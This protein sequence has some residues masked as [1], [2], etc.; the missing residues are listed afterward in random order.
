MSTS[1]S[2]VRT[3]GDHAV[4]AVVEQPVHGVGVVHRPHDHPD[5]G[6]VRA[7]H[8]VVAEHRHPAQP[9]R[10]VRERGGA[11]ATCGRRGRGELGQG[12]P[13]QRGLHRPGRRAPAAARSHDPRAPATHTRAAAPVVRQ[14]LGQRRDDGRVLDVDRSARRPGRRRRASASGSD[15][16]AAQHRQRDQLGERARPHRP[17]GAGHP[18]EPGVVERDELPVGGQP[19]VGL[20][21]AHAER[22]GAARTPR[23][24]SRRR[25]PRRRGGRSASGPGLSQY[26]TRPGCGTDDVR[27]R[28]PDAERVRRKRSRAR[29]RPRR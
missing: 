4:H 21:V 13:R 11:V 10:D 29:G 1:R 8:Q 18:G 26:L 28:A 5:P 14:Q 2:T 7:G 25:G 6:V 3:V 9:Q 23:G 27:R 12:A 20:E 24:C 17:A 15:R 22:V 19:D 16:A